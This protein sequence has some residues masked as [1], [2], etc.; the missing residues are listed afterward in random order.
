MRIVKKHSTTL[1]GAHSHAQKNTTLRLAANAHFYP[2]LAA[3]EKA[4]IFAA[5]RAN[6]TGRANAAQHQ[7]LLAERARLIPTFHVFRSLVLEDLR[8]AYNEDRLNKTRAAKNRRLS[9]MA[10]YKPFAALRGINK[11][12]LIQAIDRGGNYRCELIDKIQP[13]LWQQFIKLGAGY[14]ITETELDA[15]YRRAQARGQQRA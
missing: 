2:T 11:A 7:K 15:L 3:H 5:V 8:V 9:W 4:Q 10:L 1:S 14:G 12:L 13:D 6:A